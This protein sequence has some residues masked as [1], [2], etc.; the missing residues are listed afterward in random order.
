M[1][2]KV[3]IVEDDL[4]TRRILTG[5]IRNAAGF[6]LV[7]EWRDTAGAIAQLPATSPD[8][9]PVDIHLHAGSGIDVVR[10]SKPGLPAMQF[11]MLTTY[12][13]ADHIYEAL[14]G[15]CDRLSPEADSSWMKGSMQSPA[16]MSSSTMSPSQPARSSP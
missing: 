9:V 7:G 6:L 5:W 15:W 12:Q 3:G 16:T 14:G 10:G 8:V 11:L 1:T 4:E 13:D 2:I